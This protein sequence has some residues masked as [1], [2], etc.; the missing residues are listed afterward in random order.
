MTVVRKIGDAHS[1]RVGEVLDMLAKK[2]REGRLPGFI[3]IAEELGNPQPFYG[4]VGRLRADPLRAIGHLAVMKRKVAKFAADIAP[5][6]DEA[7]N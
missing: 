3:V 6:L 4:V 7:E 1:R 2:N 5:D